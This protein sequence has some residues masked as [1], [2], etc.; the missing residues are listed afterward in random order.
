M[1]GIRAPQRGAFLTGL[2][3]IDSIVYVSYAKT[4]IK[5]RSARDCT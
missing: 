1:I 5:G 4:I 3:N 2:D